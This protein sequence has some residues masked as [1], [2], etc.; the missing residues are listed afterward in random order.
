MESE[1]LTLAVD[2]ADTGQGRS[3]SE[4]GHSSC[5]QTAQ[6][7]LPVE[8]IV[9]GEMIHQP[10]Q[11]LSEESQRSVESDRLSTLDPLIHNDMP[12]SPPQSHLVYLVVPDR[13][14]VSFEE[15]IRC[16]NESQ[17]E[18][19]QIMFKKPVDGYD[20]AYKEH[21]H[22]FID[23]VSTCQSLK[24][25][26]IS[27]HKV[28]GIEVVQLLPALNSLTLD[29][30]L[31]NDGVEFVCEKMAHNCVLKNL[32]LW[33][34]H[35]SLSNAGASLGSMLAVNSTLD[36]LDLAYTDLGPN[37]VEA[38]LEP[39]TGHA[40]A[41][42][43][44]KSL[45]HLRINGNMGQGAGEAIAHMLRTNDTLTHF[46]IPN[47]DLEPS[48]VC[49]I[50]ESLQKNQTLRSL[51]LIGC[52]GVQGPDVLA[53]M[54]D[55]V[56]M[57]PCLMEINLYDT[58]L[59]REGQAAQVQAQLENNAKDYMAVL[60]G[61]PRV[62]PKFVRVFLCGN[63]YS[64]KTTLGRSMKRAF[65]TSCGSN[66]FLPLMELIELR[67]PFKFCS[68]D[69]DELSKRT[70]GIEIN[71][72]LDNTDQK[73]SL[74]DLAGQ[75]EYHAFHDMMMPD[76]SSQGNVSYFLLVCN[77]FDRESGERKSLEI[78]KEELQSWLRFI[79]SNTKRSF[80]FPPHIT[81]VITNEDKGFFIHKELVE[82][83]VKELANQ[84]RDYINV[85]LKLH[86]I[87]AH[88][89]RQ[90][91]DVVEVVTTT[92]TNVLDK[93]PHVFG[94]CVNVQ[95]GLSDWIKE[96]PYQPIVAMETFKNDIVAKKE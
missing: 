35:G 39:L 6:E 68:N 79:S 13:K 72:L 65:A 28:K 10:G 70:R 3:T 66:L 64:G 34:Y 27:G 80:N 46:S 63:A 62:P 15:A 60:R 58:P 74:W 67:K 76:L 5:E 44:N 47:C 25:L 43:R 88:S 83:Y 73:I 12:A 31:D 22:Q 30:G 71:V 8:I 16:L 95:H 90:A 55:L 4:C 42:P 82:S 26:N 1:G 59:E 38:L 85:S 92:C 33:N 41:R 45:T 91:K 87:N 37:G 96:H 86:S 75:E 29:T 18:E 77:P 11:T 51:D 93:L 57:H 23:A 7:I 56:R 32:G 53:K 69:P 84:F 94:A 17:P 81:I 89:F 9:Q 14:D 24:E 49:K 40:T 2:A 48:D 52:R 21:R 78:I 36:S 20:E 50:L 19:L 61:M 54:M